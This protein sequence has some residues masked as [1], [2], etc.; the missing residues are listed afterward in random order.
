[1]E[2]VHWGHTVSED[3]V[4]WRDLPIALHPDQEFCA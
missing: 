4:H 3:L 1:M 2:R